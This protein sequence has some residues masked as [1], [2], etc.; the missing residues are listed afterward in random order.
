MQACRQACRQAHVRA[1]IEREARA[2]QVDVA[3]VHGHHHLGLERLGELGRLALPRHERVGAHD[4]L[5]CVWVL[6]WLC[7]EG[8]GWGRVVEL[9][10]LS[11]RRRSWKYTRTDARTHLLDDGRD[12]HVGGQP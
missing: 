1:Y 6:V 7:T 2:A 9:F 10:W 8:V 12:D 11:L 3:V 4:E 5:R